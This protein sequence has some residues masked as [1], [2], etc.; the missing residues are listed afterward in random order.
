MALLA[1]VCHESKKEPRR[2]IVS[3][4]RALVERA[5]DRQLDVPAPSE[6]RIGSEVDVDGAKQHRRAVMGL[7]PHARHPFFDREANR[8][9]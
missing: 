2:V 8:H 3:F 5:A 6:H 4:A 9:R 7:K 1:A